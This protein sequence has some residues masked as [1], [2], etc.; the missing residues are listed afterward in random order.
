MQE[1]VMRKELPARANLEH[2]KAQAKDLLEAFR[3][4]EPR[5]LERVRASLPALT[6]ADD[7]ALG[8]T[9]L[10]LHD[11][12]SVIARE[13]GF[14]SWNALRQHVLGPSPETLRA[15]MRLP[16]PTEVER[17][18]VQAASADDRGTLSYTSPLPLVPVRNAL[19][20]AGAIAPLNIGRPAT[21]A[22]ID[23]ARD[24]GILAVFSQR[25]DAN[26]NPMEEDLHPIGCVA[27]LASVI[28]TA[29][30]GLW[31][32]VRAIEWVRRVAIERTTPYI[33]VSVER[34]A[35]TDENSDE[36]T[37]LEP[38]L[39]QRLRDRAAVLPGAERLLSMIDRMSAQQLADAV[40]SNLQCTVAEKACYASEPSLPARLAHVLEL[41]E[42]A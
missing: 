24:G 15:L 41:L 7:A 17:A 5:A 25:D 33:A 13:Y 40:V 6:S 16:L 32:V 36:V 2:L 9:E 3:R 42:S 23:A 14:P 20:A 21:I 30:R 11:A 18:L 28:S 12:Q 34:F 35:I 38:I 1:V 39:R 27:R 29:D 19:L 37:R 4:K 26:E 31:I 22:A 10:A 8:A